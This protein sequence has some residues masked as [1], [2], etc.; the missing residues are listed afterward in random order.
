MRMVANPSPNLC[1]ERAVVEKIANFLD[2]AGSVGMVEACH[3]EL[4][5]VHGDGVTGVLKLS[6]FQKILAAA[7]LE[8]ISE[9]GKKMQMQMQ[10]K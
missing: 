4:R 5:D 7:Y 8:R 1:K 2:G 9:I 6:V 10:M 3:H